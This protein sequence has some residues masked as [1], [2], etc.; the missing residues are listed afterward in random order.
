MVQIGSNLGMRRQA[1]R[2]ESYTR[3][4]DW[5]E[6]VHI[7]VAVARGLCFYTLVQSI[8]I[9]IYVDEQLI[10]FY[11]LNEFDSADLGITLEIYVCI[12]AISFDCAT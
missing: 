1:C 6:A 8:Y 3:R 2:V 11:E 7:A 10:N 12:I 5:R 9:Y 4:F